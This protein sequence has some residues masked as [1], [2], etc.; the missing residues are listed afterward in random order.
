M[1]ADYEPVTIPQMQEHCN[2]QTLIVLQIETK[3]ALEARDEILSVPGIDAVMV[4]PVDLSI[5]L[6]CP[7]D[8]THPKMIAAMEAI[9]DSCIAKG[10]A[11]GTQT[12]NLELAK[13]WKDRGMKF[14]GC[15]SEWGM[16]LERGK[17]ITAAL[18]N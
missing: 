15:S 16:M 7:G 17:E 13:F 6:G 14:L 10:I 12:R 1:Q 9:R 5:S 8:F 4:G 3:R 18:S 2:A 11:P